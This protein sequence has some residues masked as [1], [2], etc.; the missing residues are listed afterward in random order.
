MARF[1]GKRFLITGGTSGIGLATAKRIVEE[2]GEVA[3]TGTTQ[4]HL[5]EAG[6]ALPSASLVL[7]NDAT[8]PDD[9][10]ELAEKVR[11]MG[12]IE[13]AYLNAGFGETM[14]VGEYDRDLMHKMFDVNVFGP[15]MQLQAIEDQIKEGGAILLTSSVAPY[16]GGPKGPV[17]A[18]TKASN[19]AFARSWANAFADRKIRVNAVAPG[20]IETAFFD[21]FDEENEEEQEKLREQMKDR[22][23]LGRMGR[24]EEVAAVAC[25]LLS[26]DASFVTG[27]EYF[28][29]G[30]MTMR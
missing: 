26:D 22:L 11:E 29:D 14:A 10:A 23:P 4:E 19:H 16:L 27:A 8:N 12:P 2:G 13:G 20:P 5:D 30:G 25:F 6:K 18:A 9:V 15:A 3:V 28:V 7:R 24:P 1:D 21:V 17:Y